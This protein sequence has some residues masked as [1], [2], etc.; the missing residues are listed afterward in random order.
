MASRSSTSVAVGLVLLAGAF[1]R[2]HGLGGHALWTDELV[3]FWAVSAGSTAELLK[4]S[5]TCMATPPLSFLGQRLAVSMLGASEWAMRL[6]SA[7]AGIAT[8]A[9]VFAAGRRMFGR[10]A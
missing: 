4:R 6:P 5:S 1:L 10:E 2:L 8:L 9:V 7:L 3:S